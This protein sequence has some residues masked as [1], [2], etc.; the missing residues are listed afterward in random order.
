MEHGTRTELAFTAKRRTKTIR[1]STGLS[2]VSFLTKQTGTIGKASTPAF[3]GNKIPFDVL[4]F[5]VRSNRRSHLHVIE[6][7]H[8]RAHGKMQALPGN[9]LTRELLQQLD[10]C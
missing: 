9:T 7:L 6:Q 1:Q 10:S 8:R 2:Y 3:E 4:S 5:F